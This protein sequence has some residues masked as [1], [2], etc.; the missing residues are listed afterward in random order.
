MGRAPVSQRYLA[1]LP[2]TRERLRGA[3]PGFRDEGWRLD[4][5]L[6]E[7]LV[8]LQRAHGWAFASEARK[9]QMLAQDTGHMP[10]VMS[11]PDAEDRLEARGLLVVFRVVSGGVMPDGQEARAGVR[12]IRVLSRVREQMAARAE[13]QQR[14][15]RTKA[16]DPSRQRAERRIAE[17]AVMMPVEKL[18]AGLRRPA[19][20]WAPRAVMAGELDEQ[21]RRK[22][23]D[24]QTRAARELEAQWEREDKAKGPGP[25]E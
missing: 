15:A 22:R 20:P 10:G 23:I 12:K 8:S 21:T 25:P 17:R 7:L 24:E 4:G 19:Q 2:R 3:M 16:K 14:L 18:L 13:Y 9:R 11:I 5:P 1:P 6:L